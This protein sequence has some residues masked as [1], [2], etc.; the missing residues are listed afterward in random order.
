MEIISA[1][2]PNV[3]AGR[4][5]LQS[6]AEMVGGLKDLGIQ[7]GSSAGMHVHINA[8]HPDVVGFRANKDTRED[9]FTAGQVLNIWAAYARFQLVIHEM[10]QDPRIGNHFAKPLLLS[11]EHIVKGA[12]MTEVGQAWR[13]VE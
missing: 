9:P 11:E 1:G 10:L 12:S 8:G 2:P 4:S 7:A 6:L 13:A 3:L 5:G